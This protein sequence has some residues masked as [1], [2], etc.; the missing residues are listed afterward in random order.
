MSDYRWYQNVFISRVM[1][2]KDCLKSY[3]KENFIAGLPPFFTYKVKEELIGKNDT[4]DYDNLT[5]GVIFSTI[6]KLGNNMCNDQKMLKQHLKN[7]KKAKY[8]MDNVRTEFGLDLK[9][10]WIL[11]QQAQ[12]MNL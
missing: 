11:A 3:W 6:K 4:I 9:Y 12:T 5:Y 1:L 2:R 10:D 7:S 8:E